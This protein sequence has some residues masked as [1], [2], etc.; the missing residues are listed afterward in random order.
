[1]RPGADRTH[2]LMITIGT[3][4]RLWDTHSDYRLPTRMTGEVVRV[5]EAGQAYEVECCD[6]TRTPPI[7]TLTVQAA[8]IEEI[9]IYRMGPK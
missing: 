1:M 8:E 3:I 5:L 4:V 7:C 9:L 2:H 6:Y